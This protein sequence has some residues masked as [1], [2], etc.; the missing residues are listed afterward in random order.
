M[1]LDTL[2][3]GMASYVENYKEVDIVHMHAVW[4]EV[5]VSSWS[6]RQRPARRNILSP[7]LAI[8]SP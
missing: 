2:V 5:I 1:V 8:R 6:L 4:E 7:F 3:N